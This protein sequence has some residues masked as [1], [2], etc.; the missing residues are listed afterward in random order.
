MKLI[1]FLHAWHPRDVSAKTLLSPWK[2]VFDSVSW[3]Q[4]MHRS[5]VPKL[6]VALQ[7]LQI[8][9]E[10]VNLDQFYWVMSWS[11]AITDHLMV[12]LMVKFFYDKWLQ[13]SYHWLCSKPNFS[14]IRKWYEH[15][16]ELL[17]PELLASESIQFQLIIALNMIDKAVDGV[18]VDQPKEWK[19]KAR[20]RN[21]LENQHRAAAVL[22]SMTRMHDLGGG[23]EM[24]LKEV[25]EAH[26]QRHGLEFKP[27]PGRMHNG[28]Q[29]YGYGSIRIIADSLKKKIY[30]PKEDC[31]VLTTLEKLLEM[32]KDWLAGRNSR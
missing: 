24:S 12:D 31:W 3:E 14:E 16:K 23:L 26:A 4:L 7:E 13:F 5:I 22:N 19:F 17:P 9:Q 15:W 20:Q 8:N 18:T 27:K 32:H 2:S 29:I 28:Q 30:A 21:V 25:I 10:N 6:Q 11:F 1:N